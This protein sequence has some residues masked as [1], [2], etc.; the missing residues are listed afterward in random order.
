MKKNLYRVLLGGSAFAFFVI[1]ALVT[2]PAPVS[3]QLYNENMSPT[4]FAKVYQSWAWMSLCAANGDMIDDVRT[5][6][7]LNRADVFRSTDKLDAGYILDSED[8]VLQCDSQND[9]RIAMQAG[10]LTGIELFVDSGIYRNDGDTRGFELVS[11]TRQE[12]ARAIRGAYEAKYPNHTFS[13][14]QNLPSS[15]QYFMLLA[16]FNGGCEAVPDG[17]SPI[18]I[19]IV[20]LDDGSIS[21]NRFFYN[22]GKVI[23]VG[24]GNSEGEDGKM[25]CES[26]V[27]YLRQY[28]NDAAAGQ[29]AFID[30]GGNP[31]EDIV[32]DSEPSEPT[33]ESNNALD[34][35]WWLCGVLQSVDNAVTALLD[36]ADNLLSIDTNQLRNNAQLQETWSY[37]RAIASF[38]LLAIGLAM[39]ISQALGSG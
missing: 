16:A 14:Q 24:Y 20:N 36:V 38:A 4:K 34:L 30:A 10:E 39:V 32:D 37:F 11:G 26:I 8:G 5:S 31:D 13:V 29:R 19:P 12:R 35:N 17:N 6:D 23:S 2:F 27:D 21:E 18:V 22:G 15:A 1:N 7:Q 33:C 3:A 25:S 28:A 9:S